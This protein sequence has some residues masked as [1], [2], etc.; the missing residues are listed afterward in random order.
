MG[1]QNR[2]FQMGAFSP[3]V[4]LGVLTAVLSLPGV[5]ASVEITT[6]SARLV[7]AQERAQVVGSHAGH[8]A[9][10]HSHSSFAEGGSLTTNYFPCSAIPSLPTQ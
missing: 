8:Q 4:G 6:R 10:C 1:E 3:A 7:A 5:M 9:C 2:H